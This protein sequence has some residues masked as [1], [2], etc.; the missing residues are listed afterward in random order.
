[1]EKLFRRLR[2]KRCFIVFTRTNRMTGTDV[3]KYKNLYL[4][5]FNPL[6]TSFK[7]KAEVPL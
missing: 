5:M 6:F 4:L 3:Q 2:L 1:M 7:D